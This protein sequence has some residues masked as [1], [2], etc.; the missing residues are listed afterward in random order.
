MNIV[1]TLVNVKDVEE[2][3]SQITLIY[4]Y[5]A[6]IKIYLFKI[7]ESF[8]VILEILCFVVIMSNKI[9]I[10]MN[11]YIFSNVIQEENRNKFIIL[12]IEFFNQ[13]IEPIK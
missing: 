1:R 12:T 3:K 4:L 2:T 5:R 7:S 11:N 9:I 6:Q 10:R 8:Y 13:N